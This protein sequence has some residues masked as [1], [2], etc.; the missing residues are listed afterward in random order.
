MGEQVPRMNSRLRETT[1]Q[2]S[3]CDIFRFKQT[4]KILSTYISEGY[5]KVIAS[6]EKIA[7]QIA[8]NLA[9]SI[10]ISNIRR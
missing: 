8:N 6:A 5:S 3:R 10:S 9:M 1:A 4:L 2:Q 7:P